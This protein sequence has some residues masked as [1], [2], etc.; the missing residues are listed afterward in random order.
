ML[1][2]I[3]FMCKQRGYLESGGG[4]LES[5]GGYLESGGGY[6]ESGGGLF[7]KWGRLFGK[8]GEVI[9]KVGE[10]IWK[11]GEVIF[12][13]G[14]RG[15]FQILVLFSSPVTWELCIHEG[16]LHPLTSEGGREGRESKVSCTHLR[17]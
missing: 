17:R 10:V 6:L 5:G 15:N 1:Q 13:C 11:V 9:W 12:R 3:P 4:Y 7:G 2:Y 16:Q 8:W 14:W